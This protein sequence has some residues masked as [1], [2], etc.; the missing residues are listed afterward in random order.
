MA[1]NN[2]Y[3]LD[4]LIKR[5][6]LE[7]MFEENNNILKTPLI[8][9][10][11]RTTDSIIKKFCRDALMMDV[12][13]NVAEVCKITGNVV[14]P[15]NNMVMTINLKDTKLSITRKYVARKVFGSITTTKVE[16]DTKNADSIKYI[17]A[18]EG[19]DTPTNTDNEHEPI[20]TIR[21]ESLGSTEISYAHDDDDDFTNNGIRSI[22]MDL[23]NK[24]VDPDKVW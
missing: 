9:W 6:D 3:L 4:L 2:T 24:L 20:E 8:W 16:Y 22:I 19:I 18:R 21:N 13:D 10:K 15:Y 12:L 1:N 7:D 5:V 23:C 11:L 14:K 17:I